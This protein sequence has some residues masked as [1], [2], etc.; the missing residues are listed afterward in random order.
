MNPKKPKTII[1]LVIERLN[2]PADSN[3][4]IEDLINFYY[5][6]V[7]KSLIDFKETH[8]N[9]LNLGTFV[10]RPKM[11]RERLEKY[12]GMI[13]NV[14]TETIVGYKIKVD[15]EAK[16]KKILTNLKQ[17]EKQFKKKQEVKERRY[18]K[19]NSSSLEK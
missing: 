6:A 7:K 11:M 12:Q 3:E 13:S 1:P 19:E 14:N 2:L 15:C 4:L 5:K 18:G 9:V 10:S 8:I 17:W 16:V